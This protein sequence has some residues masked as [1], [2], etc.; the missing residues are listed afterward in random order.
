[1]REGGQALYL[2]GAA[3]S[4]FIETAVFEVGASL[5]GM[6]WQSNLSQA[7][8]LQKRKKKTTVRAYT[9]KH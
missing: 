4:M 1:M 3:G 8:A 9:T 6:L 5:K 2:V 7:L